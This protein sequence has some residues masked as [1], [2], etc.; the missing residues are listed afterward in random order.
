MTILDDVR[1]YFQVDDIYQVL[2]LSNKSS[3]AE[4]RRA[5]L[6]KALEIHPDKNLDQ[7][8]QDR[9]NKRF[10]IL[11]NVYTI[12]ND[13]ESR[14]IYDR[15]YERLYATNQISTEDNLYDQ[16]KLS[17]CNYNQQWNSYEHPCR[18]SGSFV[19]DNRYTKMSKFLDIF[20]VECNS[21]SNVIKILF[22]PDN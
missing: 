20:I 3:Q 21:C 6:Q 2:D 15:Q 1:A 14:F 5:Y 10:Q 18:C 19:L 13:E 22:D 8:E 17:D 12:L 4:I 7:R 9:C 16:V 11:T